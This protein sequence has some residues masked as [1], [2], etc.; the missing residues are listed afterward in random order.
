MEQPLHNIM[1]R[2][3]TATRGYVRCMDSSA[4]ASPTSGSKQCIVVSRICVYRLNNSYVA[5]GWGSDH[6]LM[7]R[8]LRHGSLRNQV[9]SGLLIRVVIVRCG[10]CL[11]FISAASAGI[12]VVCVNR[13]AHALPSTGFEYSIVV[14]KSL[15]F[16]VS[17]WHSVQ[18]FLN[19]LFKIRRTYN[20]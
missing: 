10:R 16:A 18:L 3:S 12:Y 19:V 6:I 4:S 5:I 9:A 17:V 1:L 15:W 7:H 20:N 2:H 8:R 14:R 13:S 11:I